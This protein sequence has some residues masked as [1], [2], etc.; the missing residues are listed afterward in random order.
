[1]ALSIIKLS[2]MTFSLIKIGVL[3]LQNDYRIIE[4]LSIIIKSIMTLR[5]MKFSIKEFSY[6]RHSTQWHSV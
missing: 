4:T 6:M 1:M 5:L 3:T 2:L